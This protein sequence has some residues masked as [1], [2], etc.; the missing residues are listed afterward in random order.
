[1]HALKPSYN[2][3]IIWAIFGHLVTMNMLNIGVILSERLLT[4]G[5]YNA[6]VIIK[7]YTHTHGPSPLR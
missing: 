2:T 1:M 3:E 6:N 5:V 4:A 7:S